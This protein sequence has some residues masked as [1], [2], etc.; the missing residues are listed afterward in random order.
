[1]PSPEEAAAWRGEGPLVLKQAGKIA[2]AQSWIYQTWLETGVGELVGKMP[3]RGVVVALTGSLPV[4]WVAPQD[5]F[6]VGIVADGAP[7]RAVNLHVAQNPA[8][9][10][11][12]PRSVHLPNWTQP[13]LVPR[14]SGRGN[15]VEFAAFF[16]DAVNL[17]PELRS[18]EWAARLLA[19][20]GVR[21]EIRGAER[22]DD[23]REVDVAVAVRAFARNAALNKPATKLHNAWLAGV[24]LIG[25]R[26]SAFRA[27]GD[28]LEVRNADEVIGLIRRLKADGEV[29]AALRARAS[30]RAAEVSREALRERWREFFRKELPRRV[31]RWEMR[32]PA[33]RRASRAWDRLWDLNRRALGSL[34][35]EEFVHPRR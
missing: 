16:G 12:V 33:Q 18:P 27:E 25:G 7:H 19:E 8:Q 17:A 35:L 15:R 32:T 10:R 20:T 24:P 9:Q 11:L 34:R 1:M 29:Y 23:Y 2:A 5:L 21:F 13:G 31:A 22:W 30:E 4:S 6:V 3:E 26:D 28:F 14:D